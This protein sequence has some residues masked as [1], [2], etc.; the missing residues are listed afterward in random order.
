MGS[1]AVTVTGGVR[2]WPRFPPNLFAIPFGLT[3][4]AEAWHAAEPVL[5]TAETVPDAISVVAALVWAA[6]MACY[7]AQGTRTGFADFRNRTFSPFISLAPITGMLLAATM[8]VRAFAVGQALVVVFLAATLIVGGL[9]TGEWIVAELDHDSAHPGYFLPTVAGGLI[10]ALCAS[11]VH[12][13]GL[14]EASFGIGMLC[15]VM[16]GATILNRLFFHRVLPALLVPTLA[17]EL[18]PPAVAGL[19]YF[20]LAGGRTDFF[21]SALAGY[22]VLMVVVQVRML[23]RFLRLR[24]SL[25]FWA[26]TF[27]WAATATDALQWIAMRRPPGAAAYSSVIITVIT[28]FIA[29]I[30]VRTLRLVLRGRGGERKLDGDRRAAA[31]RAVEGE[32]AAEGLH[33]V[34]QAN[35]A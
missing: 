16:I 18:A 35:E 6:L 26:F 31:G 10:G 2:G 7:G 1:F 5:G 34:D 30:A 19:A 8:S 22:A 4:L 29:V 28:V 9:L 12:L 11:Q 32:P 27:S 33:P 15:W 3:G 23:P 25:A 14:A 13:R 21:A 20:A 24:F 17:I